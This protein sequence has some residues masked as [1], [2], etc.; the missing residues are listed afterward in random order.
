MDNENLIRQI[1]IQKQNVVLY[2]NECHRLANEL[3][4][5]NNLRQKQKKELNDRLK[6]QN[7]RQNQQRLRFYREQVT[8]LQRQN[9]R[10]K[11]K[12]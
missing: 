5:Q 12:I 4:S 11:Q 7:E 6:I 8:R 2:A 10:L 1:Q 3:L 9:D